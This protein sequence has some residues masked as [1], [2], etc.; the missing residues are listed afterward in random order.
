MGCPCLGLESKVHLPLHAVMLLFSSTHLIIIISN[1]QPTKFIVS[2]VAL[3]QL[4]PPG[5]SKWIISVGDKVD[6]SFTALGSS[7]PRKVGLEL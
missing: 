7:D 2:R 3:V 5:G 4:L 1:E 6:N